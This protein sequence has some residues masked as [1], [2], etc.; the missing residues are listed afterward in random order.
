MEPKIKRPY[1][2]YK[3]LGLD[4]GTTIEDIKQAYRLIIRKYR[5]VIN[6]MNKDSE[7][8][9]IVKKINE[10][11]EV[12]SHPSKR[13]VYDNSEAECPRCWT[14]EV[15]R[16]AGNDWV[17]LTW[18]CTHCGCNFT[19][20]E[21]KR[22]TEKN[23]VAVEYEKYV[24][25]RC[26]RFLVIDELGLYRCQNRRCK[27]VFS[28]YEMRKYYSKSIGRSTGQKTNQKE[29]KSFVFSSSEK[30]ILKSICG[31]S[32][33]ATLGLIYYLIFNF[34]PLILGLFILFSGFVI[35]SWYIY[36]YP[37]IIAII[38]SLITIK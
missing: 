25:P 4:K 23:E 22:E 2:Y 3:I 24:C 35:L 31:I 14:H 26:Q 15:R 8:A 34:S 36:K 13:L 38:K 9:E 19:F 29:I 30:L 11:F 16:T 27:G 7:A 33:L 20:A 18:R 21:E 10:A 32:V 1:R 17:S 6:G 28:R 5:S 37:R 12:L